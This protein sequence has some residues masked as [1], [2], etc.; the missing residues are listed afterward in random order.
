V[1]ADDARIIEI[2]IVQL[3]PAPGKGQL[4]G[5]ARWPDPDYAAWWKKAE[6]AAGSELPPGAAAELVFLV[7]IET[8]GRW[9]WP[10]TALDYRVS[11]H[12]YTAETNFGFQVCAGKPKPCRPSG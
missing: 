3:G 8:S 4:L 1:N 7:G 6:P 2:R 5:A 10:Q 9:L 11:G 12:P